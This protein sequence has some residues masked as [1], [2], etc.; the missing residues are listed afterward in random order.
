MGTE[1]VIEVGDFYQVDQYKLLPSIT[2]TQLEGARVVMVSEIDQHTVCVACPSIHTLHTHITEQGY[3]FGNLIPALDARYVMT[4][5]VAA[6][7]FFGRIPTKEIAYWKNVIEV[8]DFYQVDQYKL[9][10]SITPTQLEGARVVMVSEID[11]HTMCVACPSIHT[12]H[13]HITEQGYQFGNLI[14]ALDARYKL[15]N[16]K[17]EKLSIEVT[18][19]KRDAAAAITTILKNKD[20][21]EAGVEDPCCTPPPPGS[22]VRESWVIIV[23]LKSGHGPMSP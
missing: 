19:L 11:Q 17:V 13:T 18:M 21:N 1:N 9:L 14:P 7:V 10:P 22:L 3:Q 16:E 6:K 4:P 8:G 23:E 5:Q 15:E 12:L 20:I 2:P